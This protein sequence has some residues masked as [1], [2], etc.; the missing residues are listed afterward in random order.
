VGTTSPCRFLGPWSLFLRVYVYHLYSLVHG[1]VADSM[2][3]L[4]DYKGDLNGDV[5]LTPE[6]IKMIAYCLSWCEG[7][8]AIGCDAELY[9]FGKLADQFRAMD[10]HFQENAV[11]NA[12]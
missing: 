10:L 12:S 7:D 8:E 3:V 11:D 4:N 6:D 5:R 9:S 1:S 2:R